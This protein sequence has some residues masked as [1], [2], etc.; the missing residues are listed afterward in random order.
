[1]EN[2]TYTPAGFVDSTS[3]SGDIRYG[4]WQKICSAD[5]LGFQGIKKIISYNII[6]LYS[7]KDY[8]KSS[9]DIRNGLKN[10]QIV[11]VGL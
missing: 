6:G 3:S 7:I 4:D 5:N 2:A 9:N 11:K 8:S 10:C 1:M